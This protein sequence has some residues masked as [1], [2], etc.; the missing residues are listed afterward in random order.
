[1]SYHNYF[2]GWGSTWAT[3]R[4][5]ASIKSLS[6]PGN[7]YR[8]NGKKDRKRG[9][10]EGCYQA[11][12]AMIDYNNLKDNINK[13]TGPVQ[14][15]TYLWIRPNNC[16]LR[17]VHYQNF[18]HECKQNTP[19]FSRN[20]GGPENAPQARSVQV[21]DPNE[22]G[23]QHPKRNDEVTT[24]SQKWAG[25]ENGNAPVADREETAVL[26]EHR[27]DITAG[28][29][30]LGFTFLFSIDI[31]EDLLNALAHSDEMCELVDCE[32]LEPVPIY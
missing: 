30:Q 13:R 5:G 9:G 32:S 15:H 11:I 22:R 27:C 4:I 8:K 16:L 1:M 3:V 2:S 17:L 19:E 7:T 23:A 31:G 26:H 29:N 6:Y 20:Q 14:L 18:K 10:T 28:I 21:G 25:V 12:L 24:W